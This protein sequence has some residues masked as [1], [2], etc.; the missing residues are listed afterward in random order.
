M[1][2]KIRNTPDLNYD[3]LRKIILEATKNTLSTRQRRAFERALFEAATPDIET[4]NK[5]FAEY[6]KLFK[7]EQ[8]IIGFSVA[9]NVLNK[10]FNTAKGKE[11][12][13]EAIAQWLKIVSRSIRTLG[14]DGNTTNEKIFNNILLKAIPNIKDYG[15][16]LLTET[17]NGKKLTFITLN[18]NKLTGLADITEVKKDFKNNVERIN[19]EAKEAQNF[20]ISQV[21]GLS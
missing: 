12:K 18:E 17:K 21:E 9:K 10:N 11:A 15:F 8:Q 13:T 19:K 20:I 2:S 6:R 5:I 3:K 7:Y 1:A 16:D 14:I 4:F